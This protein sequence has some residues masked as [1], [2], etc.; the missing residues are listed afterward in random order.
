[1]VVGFVIMCVRVCVKDTEGESGEKKGIRLWMDMCH[2]CKNEWVRV[3][4]L[5]SHTG[6][7]SGRGGRALKLGMFRD[8]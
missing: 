4:H 6:F 7:C 2:D 5:P 8:E 3:T 1:M